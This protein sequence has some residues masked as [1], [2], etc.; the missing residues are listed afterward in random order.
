MKL[1]FNIFGQFGLLTA[2]WMAT[3]STAAIAEPAA[4]SQIPSRWPLPPA[5]ARFE[6][7]TSIYGEAETQNEGLLSQLTSFLFG[8]QPSR[9]FKRPHD[10]AVSAKGLMVV[11]D[12]GA[13]AIHII[14]ATNDDYRFIQQV[15][16]DRLI[17]PLGTALTAQGEILVSDSEARVIYRLSATGDSL[18]RITDKAWLRPTDIAVQP[19]TGNIY[20]LDTLGHNIHIY[21]PS[22][23][24]LGQF[25]KRGAGTGKFNYPTHL[26]FDRQGNLYV[27]D[28]MNF[29]VQIFDKLHRPKSH[30]GKLGDRLG[31]FSKPKGIALDD[32]D[33]IY[34]VDAH[35]DHLLIYDKGGHFLL[36]IGGAGTGPGLFN[37][38]SGIATSGYYIYIVDAYNRRVQILRRIG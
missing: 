27:T 14:G 24:K 6:Y 26:A 37:I 13:A 25:G 15:G 21:Y 34:I 10:I 9:H 29:R 30:F 36:P 33:T 3:L 2:M 17:S 31:E 19:V 7:V 18:G 23:K 20:V 28:S 35:F 16:E 1:Y 4:A 11:T 8:D 5:R 32:Q 38:P 22:G 12:P